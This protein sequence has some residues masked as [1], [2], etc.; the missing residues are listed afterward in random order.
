VPL[1]P[2]VLLFRVAV[3][4][5]GDIAHIIQDSFLQLPT[6]A[7]FFYPRERLCPWMVRP[8]SLETTTAT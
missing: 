4:I 8:I 2:D 5:G 3:V 6:Q 1:Q 7:W